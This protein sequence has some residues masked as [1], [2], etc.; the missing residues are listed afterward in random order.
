MK[1]AIH[2]EY[3]A[4]ATMVCACGNTMTVGS[5]SETTQVELCAKC[6]PFF[7]GK[8]K[9]VDTARRVDRFQQRAAK[10]ETA[11]AARSGK[12]VKKERDVQRRA[13]KTPKAEE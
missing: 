8:Q 11:A 1:Q 4:A 6:H 5:T 10:Q 3:Y 9:I 13:A 12:R 7:T 2:P